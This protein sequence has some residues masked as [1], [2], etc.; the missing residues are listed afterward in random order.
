MR[1]PRLPLR[2]ASPIRLPQERSRSAQQDMRVCSQPVRAPLLPA[3]MP[4]GMPSD[5][6]QRRYARGT[7]QNAARWLPPTFFSSHRPHA[8][9]RT[10]VCHARY[11]APPLRYDAADAQPACSAATR[12]ASERTIDTC[13]AMRRACCRRRRLLEADAAFTCHDAYKVLRAYA[14][15]RTHAR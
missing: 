13:A 11:A 3:A 1:T 6:P 12:C 2:R 10:A 8:R 14:Q 9:L 5:A 4:R 7:A 15:A